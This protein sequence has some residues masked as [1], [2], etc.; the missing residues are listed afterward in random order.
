MA[1]NQTE[2]Y[3]ERQERGTNQRKEWR[4]EWRQDRREI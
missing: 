3:T 4:P 2:W 1:K